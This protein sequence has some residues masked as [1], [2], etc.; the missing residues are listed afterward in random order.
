MDSQILRS[1]FFSFLSYD[2]AGRYRSNED[3]SCD[4]DIW[5]M[6]M[7]E[8]TKNHEEMNKNMVVKKF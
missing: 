2:S 3:L 6:M 1:L 4:D 7:H 5:D 8:K